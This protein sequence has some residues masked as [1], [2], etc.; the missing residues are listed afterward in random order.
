METININIADIGT[1]NG[2]D[3]TCWTD[4]DTAMEDVQALEAGTPLPFEAVIWA[5]P[6]STGV[7]LTGENLSRFLTPNVHGEM[8]YLIPLGTHAKLKVHEPLTTEEWGLYMYDV[9]SS[10][11]T[12]GHKIKAEIQ[13]S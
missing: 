8:F 11:N 9:P 4:G 7:Q 5:Q 1:L 6:Q 3:W 10:G 13:I 12:Y 2:E